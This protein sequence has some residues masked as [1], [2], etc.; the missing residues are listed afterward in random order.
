MNAALLARS[1]F[2]A[3]RVAAIQARA[4]L[5]A[6]ETAGVPMTLVLARAGFAADAFPDPYGVMSLAEL[7]RLTCLAVELTGNTSFGLHWAEHSPMFCFD[8]VALLVAQAPTVRAGLEAL[9]RCQTILGDHREVTLEESALGAA[10]RV[11]PLALS[12]VAARVRTELA[13][14]GFLRL[15]GY[16]GASAEG[17]IRRIDF[18][19][20]RP[21][22]AAHYP[23][24]FRHPCRFRQPVSGI[25]FDRSWL[26]RPLPN[27]NPELHQLIVSQAE[28]VLGRVEAHSR[29]SEQLRSQLRLSFPHPP[30]MAAL[31]RSLG[32]SERSLRRR[33]A[34]EGTSYSALLR[35]AQCAAAELLLPDR[36][37]S[38]QQ[39]AAHVGFQSVTA[40]N[41]AF[42]RHSGLTP[43]QYR[44]QPGEPAQ[45][46]TR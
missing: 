26:D 42:K 41:R 45:P 9:L 3:T 13:L 40:F 28:R 31:A 30:S 7:D 4:L 14:A 5:E 35:E 16:A 11:H 18:A 27:A 1:P 2:G 6:V 15:L 44:A 21:A 39:V 8:V 20:A 25:E 34:E 33:L 24:V 43:S 10:L 29:L 38:V 46:V 36:G 17:D 19:Y 37:R 12:E 32:T 22:D 23:R